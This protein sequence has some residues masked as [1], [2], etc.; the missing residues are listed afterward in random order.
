MTDRIE[1]LLGRASE[2]FG[3]PGFE[4][5]VR[6]IIKSELDPFC[7]VSY[8]KMGSVICR[9]K[10]TSSSPKVM[11]AAHMD[12]VGFMVEAV[13]PDGAAS[14]VQLGG[15]SAEELP[16]TAVTLRTDQGD[17]RGVI[18]SIPVHFRRGKT[19]DAQMKFAADQMFVDFGAKNGE[20]AE[21]FGVRP[22]TPVVPFTEFSKLDPGDMYMGKAWDNRAGCVVMIETIHRLRHED[23]PNEVYA[24]GTVQEEVGARG[25]RTSS[26]LI[27]P[28]L[29]I[30]LEGSPARDT[31]NVSNT[32][33]AE[34]G[35]GP[36]IR[37]YDP[38]M[39]PNR[40]LVDLVIETAERHGIQYQVVVRRDGGTDG[41]SIH[42]TGVGV[43][44]MVISVPCR[45]IHSPASLMS[46][47]DLENTVQLL[48]SFLKEYD[49][50]AHKK[51]GEF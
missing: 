10:G 25:A 2:A 51:L 38:T 18:G 3:P 42:T 1:E 35:K 34:V 14:F 27:E 6:Q 22:G 44:S 16:G 47:T 4:S 37:Y 23:H 21:R 24:V 40:A 19:P 36:Q 39:V 17:L 30:V 43:P 26:R 20:D 33:G 7:D 50:A 5:D 9:K 15:W 41:Q 45:Y 28:D 12:E 13:R 32:Q 46:G 31:L 49:A 29:A 48:L 11:I 8:D